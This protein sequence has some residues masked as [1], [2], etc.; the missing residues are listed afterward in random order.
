MHRST[1]R[2][3]FL[4]ASLGALAAWEAYPVFIFLMNAT[5][6]AVNGRLK[7]TSGWGEVPAGS[8]RTIGACKY[9]GLCKPPERWLSDDFDGIE[10]KLADGTVI[11]VSRADFEAAAECRHLAWHY[12][13]EGR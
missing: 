4:I 10:I 7:G 12:R 11:E 13:F 2:R 5:D 3:V 8:E 9:P 6:Q 1:S